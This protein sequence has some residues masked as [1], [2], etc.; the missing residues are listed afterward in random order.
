M[1]NLL[2]TFHQPVHVHVVQVHP[3]TPA[4]LGYVVTSVSVSACAMCSGHA[5]TDCNFAQYAH[6]YTVTRM[7]LAAQTWSS[8]VMVVGAPISCVSAEGC[9]VDQ[10]CPPR[11]E[12]MPND[13]NTAAS[14]VECEAGA[15]LIVRLKRSLQTQSISDTVMTRKSPCRDPGKRA[16]CPVQPHIRIHGEALAYSCI[17]KCDKNVRH[18]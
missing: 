6:V 10:P 9:T 13:Y 12:L 15:L 2:L 3:S 18:P 4:A 5:A 11:T 16:F 14:C 7:V 1:L 8:S 17:S